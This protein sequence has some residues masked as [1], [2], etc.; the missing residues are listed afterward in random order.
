MNLPNMLTMSRL[1]L[2]AVMLALLQVD[3]PYAKSLAL[4]TFGVASFTDYL[5]GYIA[6]RYNLITPFGQLMDPLT[7]KVLV[8]AAFVSFV[9][10]HLP[11]AG[12]RTVPLVPAWIAVLIIAREFLVTGLRL[13]AA[14]RGTVLSAERWGKHKT[15]WQIAAIVLI[16]GGL[17]VREDLARPVD[18]A[19]SLLYNQVFFNVAHGV[20][21]AVAAIT[22]ISGGLYFNRHR[23]ILAGG[24]PA[25]AT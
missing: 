1:A 11:I 21:L 4:I 23:D 6:R 3:L 16:L 12:G 9:E 20:A 22:L 14:S 5:D 18:E 2:V 24:P 7:D 19:A 10:I 13:L 25:R 15:I 8:C 17:A